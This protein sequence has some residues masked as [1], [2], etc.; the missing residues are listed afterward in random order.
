MTYQTQ[1]IILKKTDHNEADQLFSIY[2][3][4]KGKILALGK[5]TKKI[6]SKLNSS[7][8]HFAIIDLMIAPGKNYDHIAGVNLIK[9]FSQIKN[10]LKKIILASFSL[11]LVEKLTKV[12]MPDSKIFILLIKYLSAINDNSFTPHPFRSNRETTQLASYRKGAGFTQEEWRTIKQAFTV[13]LLALLGFGPTADVI[14]DPKKLGNFLK[15]HL[16]FELQ[17]EKF[18][19]KI[20]S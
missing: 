8:Q 20:S 15:Q 2:T 3:E 4:K 17:T 11:E 14:S 10:D 19:T 12:G 5:G 16:D 1:G 6:Q 9:N 18:L 7:L 13:E